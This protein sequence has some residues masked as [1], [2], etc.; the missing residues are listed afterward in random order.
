M[1]SVL[2]TRE[3]ATMVIEAQRAIGSA[4][5]NVFL[6]RTI[7]TAVYAEQ[8]EWENASPAKAAGLRLHFEMNNGAFLHG[9][10]DGVVRNVEYVGGPTIS[11]VRPNT[12][13]MSAR[14]REAIAID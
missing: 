13:R 1:S 3:R 2:E 10:L 11:W 4:D 6:A 5:D 7:A 12:Y 14:I 8:L 9:C